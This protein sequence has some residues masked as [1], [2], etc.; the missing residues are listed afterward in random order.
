MALLPLAW[1]VAATHEAAAELTASRGGLAGHPKAGR[2][3]GRTSRHTLLLLGG[4]LACAGEE[5]CRQRAEDEPADVREERGAAPVCR[6]TEQP[7]IP[8]D[9]LVQEPPPK[10]DPGWDVDKEDGKDPGAD[11]RA[12]IQQEVGAQHCGDG[13]ASPQ[14]RHL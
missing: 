4:D 6:G 1:A 9:Q 10:E 3:P 11:P 7:E 2:L 12:G 13:A 14:V 8:L 5:P